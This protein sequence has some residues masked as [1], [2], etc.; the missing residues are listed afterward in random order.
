MNQINEELNKTKLN[1]ISLKINPFIKTFIENDFQKELLNIEKSRKVKIHL[2]EDNN[3]VNT[4][5]VFENISDNKVKTKAKKKIL[6]KKNKTISKK[7]T[8][9]S[10][11]ENDKIVE[12]ETDKI[13]SKNQKT[14][15]KEIKNKKKGWWQK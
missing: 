12:V 10:L 7:S 3:L 5:I 1:S 4:E 11:K 14:Q 15:L 6:K 9:K 13:N 2:I 8:K